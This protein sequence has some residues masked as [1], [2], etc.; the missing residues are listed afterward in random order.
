MPAPVGASL[1]ILKSLQADRII[2]G[3]SGGKDSL[4]VLDLCTRVF[5]PERILAYHLEMLPGAE[6]LRP[7]LELCK[8]RYG[9]TPLCLP[10]PGLVL[11]LRRSGWRP[12]KWS[13]YES[14][15]RDLRWGD[16]EAVVRNRAIQ[17][18]GPLPEGQALDWIAGGQRRC[19]SLQRAAML[20]KGP[21][22]R[23]AGSGKPVYRVYPIRDWKPT[24]VV[25]Y[26]KLRKLPLPSM[27]G[28]KMYENSEVCWRKTETLLFLREHS[29]R[30]YQRIVRLFPD[31][32]GSLARDEVRAAHGISHKQVYSSGKSR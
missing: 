23:E 16:I 28:S 6:I 7:A 18:W 1:R 32:E 4:A 30:D 26:L 21:I 29:P 8:D 31:V 9:I 17:R 10:H 12:F 24:D 11:A 25:E 27:M 3:Y 20:K 19:D 14:L 5:P 15:K 22:W 2:V 13:C